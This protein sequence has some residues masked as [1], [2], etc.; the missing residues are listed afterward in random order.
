MR[1]VYVQSDDEAIRLRF[2]FDGEPTETDR[3]S[4]SC[5]G[6]EVIS[7]FPEHPRILE[8]IIRLDV[9]ETI[10]LQ[11]DWHLVFERRESR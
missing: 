2:Y 7:D 3:D 1:R 6:T 11:H 9:P 10:P 4:V 5:V 8:E